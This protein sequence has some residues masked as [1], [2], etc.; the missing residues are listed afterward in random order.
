MHVAEV[1]GATDAAKR[2]RVRD[3]M[4]GDVVS[5]SPDTQVREIADLMVRNR[6][7]SVPVVDQ[8]GR[9]VGVVSDDDLIRRAEIG[10][11]PRHSWWRLLLNDARAAAHEYVRSHGRAASDVMTRDP[12]TTTEF[13]P[14][15][16]VAALMAKRRLRRLPVVRGERVVGMISRTDLVRKLAGLSAV[17][18]DSASAGDDAVRE[19]VVQ[20][21][22]SMPWNLRIKAVNTVVE[23]GVATVYGWVGSDIERR[24]LRVAVENTPGVRRVEDGVH[25]VLPYV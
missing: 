15:H 12:V 6:I 2:M 25:T 16:K 23:D 19:R 4:S 14:L 1:A 13:T 17:S 8:A 21:T 22:R 7:S 20:R 24:A 9:L 10:T 11:E 18:S 3:V 5:A